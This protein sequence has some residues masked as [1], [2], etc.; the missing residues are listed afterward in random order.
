MYQDF[1]KLVLALLEVPI[2]KGWVTKCE[3]GFFNLK[4]IAQERLGQR[5][6]VVL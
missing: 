6:S 4:P 3:R 1:S 2:A 5:I